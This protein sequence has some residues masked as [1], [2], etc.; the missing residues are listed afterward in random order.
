[1]KFWDEFI[2]FGYPKVFDN[3]LGML[4][5]FK[6]KLLNMDFDQNMKFLNIMDRAY[7]ANDLDAQT[8]D[9]EDSFL[10]GIVLDEK[11]AKFKHFGITD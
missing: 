9:K 7:Y 6:D 3:I 8:F 11:H 1:M 4:N 2:L 10:I 5:M